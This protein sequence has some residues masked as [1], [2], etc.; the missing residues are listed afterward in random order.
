MPLPNNS[1]LHLICIN[2]CL[3]NV[4]YFQTITPFETITCS[5]NSLL[6]PTTNG[7]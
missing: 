3:Y 6:T 5:S 4:S 1:N 7:F 2:S